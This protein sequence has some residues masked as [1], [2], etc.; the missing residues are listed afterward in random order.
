RLS[1]GPVRPRWDAGVRTT[2]DIAPGAGTLV[3]SFAARA[4]LESFSLRRDRQTGERATAPSA[5]LRAGGRACGGNDGGR[6][7]AW[8]RDT[9]RMR[10]CAPGLLC[11]WDPAEGQRW[12][13]RNRRRIRPEPRLQIRA[14]RCWRL[15]RILRRGPRRDRTPTSRDW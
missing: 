1:S 6:A 4:G 12:A 14:V 10:Q 9:L 13:G 5:A 2:F 7:W 3:F 8:A 15:P 11:R